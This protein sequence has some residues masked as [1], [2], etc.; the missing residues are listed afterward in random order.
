MAAWFRHDDEVSVDYSPAPRKCITYGPVALAFAH[1]QYERRREFAAI[2]MSEFKEQ[3]GRCKHF[4]V[5]SAH[6]HKKNELKYMPCDTKDGGV[7]V[8]TIASLAGTDYWHYM[9]GFH[10]RPQSAELFVWH[11]EAG[12]YAHF[13]IPARWE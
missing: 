5:H 13:D 2:M 1:G 4:E 6:I 8:R 3:F 12:P 10:P 9:H 7:I 11:N